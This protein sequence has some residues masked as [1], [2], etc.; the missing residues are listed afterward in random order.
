MKILFSRLKGRVEDPSPRVKSIRTRTVLSVK[1]SQLRIELNLPFDS[2]CSET[3]PRPILLCR[4]DDR[5]ELVLR[6]FQSNREYTGAAQMQYVNF[7]APPSKATS[8]GYS[9]ASNKNSDN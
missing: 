4:V 5:L 7:T 8:R 2:A 1:E 6:S 9:P 3:E